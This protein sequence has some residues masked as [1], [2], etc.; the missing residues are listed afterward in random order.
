MVASSSVPHDSFHTLLHIDLATYTWGIHN[1]NIQKQS[2]AKH[3]LPKDIDWLNPFERIYIYIYI[4]PVRIVRH[5][6]GDDPTAALIPPSET[7]PLPPRSPARYLSAATRRRRHRHRR[8]CHRN[9]PRVV[10][11]SASSASWSWLPWH[12]TKRYKK[13]TKNPRGWLGWL[14]YTIRTAPFGEHL[15]VCLLNKSFHL[16]WRWDITSQQIISPSWCWIHLDHAALSQLGW[17]AQPWT[18]FVSL[19]LHHWVP[20]TMFDTVLG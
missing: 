6:A 19:V 7:A 5:L 12:T 13:H 15:V 1:P 20:P 11:R 14:E 18:P 8:G 10:K 16:S 2:P 4:Y 3:H 9:S 17:S